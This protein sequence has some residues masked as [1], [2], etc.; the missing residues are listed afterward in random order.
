ALN[1]QQ[2]DQE[3]SALQ[4]ELAQ[5][6]TKENR[7]LSMAEALAQLQDDYQQQ[8]AQL[9]HEKTGLDQNSA[10]VIVVLG[11]GLGRDNARN[12]VVNTYTKMRLE[13]AVEQ[14]KQNPLPILLS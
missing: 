11:G 12:I 5:E 6:L 14:K 9:N 4:H 10:H 13:R 8:N 1:Q 3:I 2:P 7:T